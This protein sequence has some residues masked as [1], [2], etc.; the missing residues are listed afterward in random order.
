[1]AQIHISINS[2]WSKGMFEL[3]LTLFN[4][5]LNMNIIKPCTLLSLI[6]LISF[7]Q[8]DNLKSQSNGFG[9]KLGPSL[10]YQ[11]WGGGS[12]RDPLLRWHLD[13]FMDSESSDQKNVLYGQLG[14]HI[15]GGAIRYGFFFDQFGNR[16]PGG[17]YAMEFHNLVLELGIKRFIRIAKWKPFY[18][19]GLRGEYTLKTKLEIN[20]E[21]E[22]W[23]RKWNYGVSL[24]LGSEFKLSELSNIG[25]ELNIAPD[26][27]K[28]IYIPASIRRLDPWTGQPTPGYEQSTVN[29]T[30]QLTMYMRFMRIII[31]ED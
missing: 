1:M 17:S 2:L 18:A 31:Y 11:K 23:T 28:Q 26:L 7:S 6:A 9:F 3:N 8:P 22:E 16:Y 24:R 27:S 12:Q 30:L 10:G 29:T 14:Y 5:R 4:I 20:P 19:V 21:L 15:K 25:I 13:A